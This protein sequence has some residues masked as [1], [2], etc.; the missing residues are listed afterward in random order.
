MARMDRLFQSAWQP[1]TPRG[2]ARFADAS[3][4]RLWLV[5]F[6]FALLAA[7]VMTWFVR[8][9]WFPTVRAAIERLPA[10]GE[11]R[12]GQLYWESD[13]PQRLAE[14]HFLSIAVDLTHSG[15]LRGPAHVQV[16]FGR[17]SLD[18]C[19][20]FGCVS[21]PYPVDVVFGLNRTEA[22]PWWGAWWP[23]ILAAVF[24]GT[25]VGLMIAWAA[26]ATVYCVPAWLIGFA[27]NR[28]LTLRGAW[29]LCGAAQMPGALS[30]SLALAVYALGFLDPVRLGVA[31]AA[32]WVVGWVYV[33]ASP[34]LRNRVPEATT[35][36]PF[37]GGDASGGPARAAGNPFRSGRS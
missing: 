8:T 6:V 24:S 12:A 36:N 28:S 1:L 5:Q 31:F 11:I 25:A 35:G 10:A 7:G 9:A 37:A 21:L 15:E 3:A 19:T 29:R 18:L 22:G 2:V 27:A 13:T 30:F 33:G 14:G 17:G 23:A 20:L 34:L 32:H 4:G 26:L 16:E